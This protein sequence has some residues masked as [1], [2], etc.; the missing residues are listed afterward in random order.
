[1]QHNNNSLERVVRTEATHRRCA[2]PAATRPLPHM[3]ST[4]AQCDL[5][6]HLLLYRSHPPRP[7]P[8]S[9][10]Q[11]HAAWCPCHQATSCGRPAGRSA[12]VGQR[13]HGHSWRQRG[14]CCHLRQ[15]R[16]AGCQRAGQGRSEVCG[17]AVSVAAAW[18]GRCRC[19]RQ[20]R[21]AGGQRCISHP[22]ARCLPAC[23]GAQFSAPSTA[24]AALQ[25]GRRV[26]C[27]PPC[28]CCQRARVCEA[29]RRDGAQ[30]RLSKAGTDRLPF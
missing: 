10:M 6:L 17:C 23:W 27:R 18:G 14:L 7:F 19:P 12:L 5:E 29:G 11:P 2:P 30:S 25:D 1:M 13:Q 4:A 3:A 24:G 16:C 9:C 28:G 26:C 21:Q 15:C 22:Q 20:A 8:M